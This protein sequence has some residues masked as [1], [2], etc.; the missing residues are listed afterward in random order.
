MSFQIRAWEA[1]VT[2]CASAFTQPS[3]VLFSELLTAWVLCSGRHTVT[4]MIRLLG[5]A[6]RRQ[7]DAYHRFL[8]AGAWS[9]ACLWRLLAEILVAAFVAMG[10]PLELDT[11]DTLFHKTG[12]NVQGAGSFRDAVRS[13]NKRVV[14]ALGLNLV[15]LTLRVKAPWGGEPLG[16]PIRVRIYLKGGPTHLDLVEQMVTEVAT[17]FPDRRIQLCGDGAYASLAGRNLPSTHL[18]SRIRR[19]AAL[20]DMV[21]ERKKHQRGRPRKRGKRL[22]TPEQM[23]GRATKWISAYID[24]RGRKKKRLIYA[25]QVLWYKACPNKP[26]LLVI[27][28]DPDGHEADDFFFTT[29]LEAYPADVASRYCGRWSIEDTFRATKQYLGGEDPQTWKGLGPERA[30]SLAFWLYAVVWYWYIKVYG[31]KPAWSRLPWYPRKTTPSFADALAALRTSLWNR[32]IFAGCGRA[33]LRPKIATML[34]AALAQ[35]T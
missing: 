24:C 19:D 28:R 23:A 8:R 11:D 22:A 6:P 25:R 35:A 10:A 2:A 26:V 15:V 18:T 4:R 9:M 3:F 16:L 17:W 27:V 31:A 7:H 21:P 33:S 20:Y 30:A 12:R 29:D 1:L 5:P 32:R 34:V 14:Y 13:T